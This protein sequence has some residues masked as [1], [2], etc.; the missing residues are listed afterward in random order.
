M[1]SVQVV[2]PFE[3]FT[4]VDGNPLEDGFVYIGQAGVDPIANPVSTFF[5][6]ALTVPAPQPIRTKGGYASNAGVPSRVFIAQNAYSTLVKNKNSFQILLSLTSP[7]A[8]LV[9]PAS[10]T[11]NEL[12]LFSGTSGNALKGT[13]TIVTAQGR[14][15]LD[16][17]T[18]AAQRTT[19]GSTTVGDAVFVAAN[20]A[21]ARTAIGAVI[22]TDVQAQ[23]ADLQALA[24]N[25][26]SGLLVRTGAGTAAAR[27][28][29]GTANKVTVTNGDGVSGNPTL[30]LPDA[31]TLV[32]PT[33]TGLLDCTG[34]QI[35]FPATQIPSADANTLD[36]YEKGTWTMGITF[37]T[38]G[39]L[40]VVYSS[41]SGRYTK[42]GRAHMYEGTVTTTTFTYTTATGT[43]RVSGLPFAPAS[44]VP[45]VSLGRWTGV[46]SAVATP[47]I[48]G[49][50]NGTN[51]QF[52]VM[53]V[54][55]GTTATLNQANAASGVQKSIFLSGQYATA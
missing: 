19:L 28:L 50:V 52:E 7:P 6:S 11:D 5:D 15:L 26:T 45:V 40:V 2:S 12:P 27:T 14:A 46:V 29:T 22:G 47:Q 21:A 35:K 34:G 23:D 16:D 32:A 17:D 41:Q 1:A 9:G 30:T 8:F 55:A 33:V 54:S 49:Q 4:D 38:P 13:G 10:S 31:L 53:N 51:V 44:G 39:D 25:A 20:A 36:D 43:L 42:I 3:I 18:A 48:V 24:D 37:A